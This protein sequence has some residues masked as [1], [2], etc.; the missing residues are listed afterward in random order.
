MPAWP[1][2]ARSCNHPSPGRSSDAAQTSA[3]PT[4]DAASSQWPW[5]R[6]V[7]AMSQRACSAPE[8]FMLPPL[9]R[10]RRTAISRSKTTVF[11]FRGPGGHRDYHLNQDQQALWSAAV[12]RVRSR[13]SA[14]DAFRARP[15]S[16]RVLKQTFATFA[17]ACLHRST[18]A[19][20]GPRSCT[21][22]TRCAW[23]FLLPAQRMRRRSHPG[24]YS[25][26]LSAGAE[27]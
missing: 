7:C 1:R 26:R 2:H 21:C 18:H 9:N 24:A 15:C 20:L 10:Y 23:L 14:R 17:K 13:T 19:M 4:A 6:K 16:L 12:C 5:P 3:L 11:S 8:A 25:M 27:C 22:C